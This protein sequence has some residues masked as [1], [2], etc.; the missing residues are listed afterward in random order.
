MKAAHLLVRR[1]SDKFPVGLP[2]YY[3]E[4]SGSCGV[5]YRSWHLG[6]GRM[7]PARL[8]RCGH[9]W[10]HHGECRP[11]WCG[12]EGTPVGQQSYSEAT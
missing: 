8:L 4:A 9:S 5:H 1:S 7:P 11:H 3:E 6:V 2:H 12:G 10:P